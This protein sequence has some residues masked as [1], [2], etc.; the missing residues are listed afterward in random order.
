MV[1]NKMSGFA[2]EDISFGITTMFYWASS[3]SDFTNSFIETISITENITGIF[4]LISDINVSQSLQV[5]YE[6]NIRASAL[7]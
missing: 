2:N 4:Y 7:L 1:K 6:F 3:Y 5:F